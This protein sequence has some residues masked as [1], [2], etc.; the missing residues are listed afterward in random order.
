MRQVSSPLRRLGRRAVG[1][2]TAAGLIAVAFSAT[3]GRS[4][5]LADTAAAGAAAGPGPS[6]PPAEARNPRHIGLVGKNVDDWRTSRVVVGP[7]SIGPYDEWSVSNGLE[8]SVSVAPQAVSELL[9]FD[10]G[11]S[12]SWTDTK[13]I[14]ASFEVPEG[15]TGRVLVTEY[16]DE[17][18]FEVWKPACLASAARLLGV[19]TASKF[20][21]LTYDVVLRPVDGSSE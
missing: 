8:V 19:G 16:Y 10:V 18:A 1:L 20:E 2:V 13:G 7:A 15:Q 21:Y 12:G 5:A 17:Y 6:C 3:G 11:W 14:S 9:G 4:P